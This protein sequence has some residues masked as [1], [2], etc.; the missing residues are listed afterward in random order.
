M[1]VSADVCISSAEQDLSS[2]HD[3]IS[4]YHGFAKKQ[5]L[6][7]IVS[8][9]VENVHPKAR[10]RAIAKFLDVNEECGRYECNPSD[11]LDELLI[12]EFRSKVHSFL[13]PNGFPLIES[14]YQLF[15]KGT[16]STGKANCQADLSD[17]YTKLFDSPLCCT[18]SLL[19]LMW[20]RSVEAN[21]TWRR[22]E[23]ARR[24]KYGKPHIVAGSK[25][26]TVRK[27]NDIDRVACK[28]PPLNMFW[29]LAIGKTLEERL[30]E[31][32]NISLADQPEFNRELARYGSRNGYF[33]TTDLSSAS[34]TIARQMLDSHFPKWFVDYLYQTACSY[35]DVD[36]EM[37]ELRMISTMGNG[38]TFP[39]ETMI[40]S[41]CVSAAYSIAGVP[42]VRNRRRPA[43]PGNFG[44]FG[45]DIITDSNATGY[46]WRLLRLLGFKINADKTFNSGPFRE[47]CGSDYFK[48]KNVRPI[49][50]KKL[51]TPQDIYVACNRIVEYTSKTGIFLP[52]LYESLISTLKH[53]NR[54]PLWENTEAGLRTP[55][56][57]G[58]YRPYRPSPKNVRVGSWYLAPF[59]GRKYRVVSHRGG[60]VSKKLVYQ[61]IIALNAHGA[62]L[63]FLHG[64]IRDGK[65]GVE[66]QNPIYRLAKKRLAVNPASPY[67]EPEL[68]KEQKVIRVADATE[69]YEMISTLV[70]VPR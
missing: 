14:Y 29:Q 41:C 65:I 26:F 33:G 45:D 19:A 7:N 3:D 15:Q 4:T 27:R 46:L 60:Q 50:L 24:W 64:T 11:S 25:L 23:E 34:D 43:K 68:P 22:A 13:N 52:N 63:S 61:P 35:V 20:E 2:I 42:L 59:K 9:L 30:R 39:L 56:L 10:D 49:F 70:S 31:V 5:L 44:V 40:F 6:E 51:A 12:G 36:G 47:S 32:F 57:Q 48:G 55:N 1:H 21:P 28:E 58:G 37:Q 66:R 67:S 54:V 8:K 53:V 18:S 69:W 38:F 17:L 62:F 16:V